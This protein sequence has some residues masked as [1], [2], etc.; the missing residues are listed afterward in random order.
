MY[1]ISMFPHITEYGYRWQNILYEEEMANKVL[2]LSNTFSRS[3]VLA[4]EMAFALW[5][6][7]LKDYTP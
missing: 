3:C 2:Y 4:L 1:E 7:G 5:H 6:W